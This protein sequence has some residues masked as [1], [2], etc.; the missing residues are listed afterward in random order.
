VTL[1]VA[2]FAAIFCSLAMALYVVSDREPSGS[3]SSLL[4][5]APLLG[6]V[7]WVQKDARQTGVGP[8]LDFGY[9]VMLAWPIAIPWYAFKTR[10][11]SG[12]RLMAG[13]FTL[14]VAPYVGGVIAGVLRLMLWTNIR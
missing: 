1:N 8:F 7:L 2:V 11:R 4:T 6:A 9:F 3:I 5:F 10:G 12:W 14:I 13:L